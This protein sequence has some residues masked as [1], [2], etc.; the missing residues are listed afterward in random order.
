[1]DQKQLPRLTIQSLVKLTSNDSI[2]FGITQDI[3]KTSLTCVFATLP[4]NITNAYTV[5]FR[6]HPTDKPLDVPVTIQTQQPTSDG[7]IKAE[8]VFSN[9]ESIAIQHITQFIADEWVKRHGG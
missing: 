4:P 7:R 5:S 1:M 9:T 8:L 3:G 2:Y 6:L